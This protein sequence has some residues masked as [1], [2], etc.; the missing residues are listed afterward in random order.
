MEAS[1]AAFWAK[2]KL[3]RSEKDA[4]RKGFVELISLMSTS[5]FTQTFSFFW[6]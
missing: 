6:C 3:E 5:V 1:Y 4:A 2:R